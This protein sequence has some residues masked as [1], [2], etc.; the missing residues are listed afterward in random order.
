M[1]FPF[2]ICLV[3][4]IGLFLIFRE[5][6]LWYWKINERIDLQKRILKELHKLNE[7]SRDSF[8]DVSQQPNTDMPE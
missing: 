1:I 6:N 3:V 7:A 8:T 4:T 2:I 5:L